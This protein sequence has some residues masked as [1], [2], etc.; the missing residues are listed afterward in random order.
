MDKFKSMHKFCG[1]AKL[2]SKKHSFKGFSIAALLSVLSSLGHAQVVT[3]TVEYVMDGQA[4]TGLFA[5]DD[6]TE[7]KRPGVVVVHEWWGANDYAH[8]RAKDLAKEGYVAFAIDMYGTGK[9]ADHPKQA[10]LFMTETMEKMPVAE[11]RFRKGK[12][13]LSQHPRVIKDKIAAIGYC[14]GGGI[15]LHMARTGEELKGVAS[16]HGS[17]GA[18]TEAKP[19]DVKAKIRVY[20]G[21]KDPF[22]PEEQIAAFKDEMNQLKADYEVINYSNAT[23]SFTNP[24][25]DA[26]GKKFDMPLAYDAAAD[27]ESWQSMLEFFAEIFK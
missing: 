23:H 18:K 12:E 9:V 21:A 15:V 5:Y 22:V 6:S 8:K 19:G 10:K 1:L 13:I 17:L 7:Q 20:N 11:K 26:V 24:G 16:F 27:R 2:M 14:F 4:F 25:A 3:E